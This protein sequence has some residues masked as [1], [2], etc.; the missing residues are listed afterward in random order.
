MKRRLLSLLLVL[1]MALGMLPTIAV[2]APAE[3]EGVYQIGTAEE[4]HPRCCM[5]GAITFS[6]KAGHWEQS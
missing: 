2:A 6:A 4:L 1:V 3:S 5:H